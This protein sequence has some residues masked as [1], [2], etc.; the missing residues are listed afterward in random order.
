MEKIYI[1]QTELQ[2]RNGLSRSLSCRFAET[3]FLYFFSALSFILSFLVFMNMIMPFFSGH[4]KIAFSA[5]NIFQFF[6]LTLTSYI[7]WVLK[8]TANLRVHIHG[9]RLIYE[10]KEKDA[11]SF[12]VEDIKSI[13]FKHHQWVFGFFLVLKS[14]ASYHFPMHLER[15]DYVLDTLSFHRKD[16]SR[17]AGFS[18]FREKVVVLDHMLAHNRSYLSRAHIKSLSFYFIYPFYASHTWKRLKVDPNKVQ[19]DTSYEKKMETLCHKVN[20]GIS[21]SMLAIVV[22]WRM[23]I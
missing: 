23:H 16:L 4:F 20:I 9:E 21:L 22:L 11:V 15:L 18:K 17:T 10:L 8:K 2:G 19:R 1:S 13:Q 5:G 14:G 12:T 6:L 3:P 7:S